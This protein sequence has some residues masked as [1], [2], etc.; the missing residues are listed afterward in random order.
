L[1]LYKSFY[2]M[3]YKYELKDVDVEFIIVKRKL[4]EN[5]EYPQKRFQKVSP[6]SGTITTNSVLLELKTFVNACFD[7]KGNYRTDAVYEK[8]PDV[9]TC[10]YCDFKD[11][12]D[13]CHKNNPKRVAKL[14]AE[15][16]NKK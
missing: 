11:R 7:E 2:A 10:R 12:P 1:V 15:M 4:Y 13:I 14:I 5:M 6:A 8:R 3:Q 9:K 16:E